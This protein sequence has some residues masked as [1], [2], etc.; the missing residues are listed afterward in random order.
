[1]RFRLAILVLAFT[2]APAFAVATPWQD[3][4]AGARLRLITSDVRAPDGTTLVGLELDMPDADKTYWRLPGESGIP[5]EIDTKGSDGVTSAAI[6]WPYPTP[7]VTQGFLDYVYHG[8]TVLPVQLKTSG[9]AT[10][11]QAS[12]IMG[13]CSDVCVPVRTRF[14]LPLSFTTPDA[15]NGLRLRQAEA[16]APLPWDKP[17]PAFANV[18]FDTTERALRLDLADA[19]IDPDSVIASTTDP[20]IVFDAPQKSPDGRSILLKVR[21]RPQSAGWQ[22]QPVLL[23][24]TTA[25][26][27]YEVSAPLR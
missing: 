9:G 18:R 19:T 24:F 14:S 7:E 13:V 27:S 16:L 23:T 4:G 10:L 20:T 5:T 8:H 17:Q 15:A 26:G 3:V 25:A 22:A 2:A 11:L 12:V 21:G 6:E 1:M